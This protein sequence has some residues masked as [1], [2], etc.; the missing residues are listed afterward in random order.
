MNTDPFQRKAIK[1]FN[2]PFYDGL[3]GYTKRATLEAALESLK[4]YGKVQP[5]F[6][7]LKNS[8]TY[9]AYQEAVRQ[10][11][12]TFQPSQPLVRLSL[13]NAVDEMPKNTSAGF[14]FPSKKKGEVI[15]EIFDTASYIQHFVQKDRFVYTPPCKLALR[16]HLSSIDE[17][18]TRPVWI[19]PAEIIALEAK[20]SIPFTAHF[21]SLKT[22]FT[23]DNTMPNVIDHISRYADDHYTKVIMDYSKYDQCLPDFLIDDVFDIIASSFD[24]NYVEHDGQVIYQGYTGSRQ[25]SNLWRYLK[26]Y[27]TRTKLMLPDGTVIR[28]KHGVPSGSG[29]TAIVDT[30]ANYI[31]C[32]YFLNVTRSPRPIHE[33]YLGDDA[34]LILHTHSVVTQATVNEWGLLATQFFGMTLNPT[35]TKVVTQSK[36]H[37]VIGYNAR[38]RHLVRYDEHGDPDREWFKL[39]LYSENDV[40]SLETSATRLYA[41]YI[42]GGAFSQPFCEYYRYFC[43]IYPQCFNIDLP[44]KRKYIRILYQAVGHKGLTTFQF[45]KLSSIQCLKDPW[46]MTSRK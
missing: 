17:Q 15:E 38:N 39:L 45:P 31:L 14:S 26:T 21:A 13:S 24:D 7:N 41:Y 44:S 46:I 5:L 23:G 42:L 33:H 34:E 36:D 10:A 8:H 25:S 4:G 29:F 43:G 22:T 28:K 1:Q 11:R 6:S 19:Y 9:P 20:W 16:G 40:E 3:S 35:K 30:I 2:R 18:K 12:L 27:F 37:K 32:H